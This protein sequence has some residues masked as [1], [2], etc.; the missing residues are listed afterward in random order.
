[1]V[2][3]IVKG[4]VVVFE[5]KRDRDALCC[6]LHVLYRGSG[7]G[8]AFRARRSSIKTM[9]TQMFHRLRTSE[10]VVYEEP[11]CYTLTASVE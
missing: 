2:V 1:M 3:P 5:E 11:H 6:L 4:Q 7:N 10:A 8:L 9:A